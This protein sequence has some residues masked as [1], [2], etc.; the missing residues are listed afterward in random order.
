[1][2]RAA[3]TASLARV[4]TDR[5]ESP[6]PWVLMTRPPR[7]ATVAAISSW[8]RSRGGSHHPNPPRRSVGVGEAACG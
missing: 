1:M 6:S 2:A 5:V 3:A 8:W 7:A 4:K